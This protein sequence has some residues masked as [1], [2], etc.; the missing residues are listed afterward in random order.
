MGTVEEGHRR[1]LLFGMVTVD[2]WGEK[3]SRSAL[4]RMVAVDLWEERWSSCALSGMIT[5][6][7]WGEMW[8][9]CSLLGMVTV[10]LWGE[11]WS[12]CALFGMVTLGERW[13]KS[14]IDDDLGMDQDE[15]MLVPQLIRSSEGGGGQ[16]GRNS[17]G[18]LLVFSAEDYYDQ[19]RHKQGC[20]LFDVFFTQHFLCRPRRRPPP[21]C[22]EG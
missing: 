1:F 15:V 21:R 3:W 20:P 8:S 22:P 7:L 6:G 5:E 13:T 18:P 11:R 2:L 14:A 17:R 19:F 9:R 12:R 16:E 4:F 10:Y